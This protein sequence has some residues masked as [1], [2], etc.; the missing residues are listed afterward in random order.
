MSENAEDAAHPE[1]DRR[2][3]VHSETAVNAG[4]QRGNFTA[5]VP[6]GQLKSSAAITRG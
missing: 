4:R 1:L 2:S 3:T 5:G 6:M